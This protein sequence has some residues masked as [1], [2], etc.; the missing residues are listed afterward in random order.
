MFILM[1]NNLIP[2]IEFY[3]KLGF[4]LNFHVPEKW[5]EFDIQG[6][7][8]GIAQT[9]QELP[10]R[11]TGIVLEVPDLYA[12]YQ[13]AKSDG[14][15]FLQE[16]VQAVHGIIASFKDPGNNILDVYQPMPE[17]VKEYIKKAHEQEK[18]CCNQGQDCKCAQDKKCCD[19]H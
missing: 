8:L 1:G 12:F 9:E 3:K 2:M 11:R 16:P 6:V 17:R 14:V 13:D 19:G 7:K 4:P 18:K 5:A 10:E 15:E